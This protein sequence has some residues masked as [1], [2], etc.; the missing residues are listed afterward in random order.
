MI[1]DHKMENESIITCSYCQTYPDCKECPIMIKTGG[2][3][4]WDSP[5][6]KFDNSDVDGDQIVDMDYGDEAHYLQYVYGYR[7]IVQ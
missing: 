2:G 4:L 3:K 5:E 1:G 7:K 6:P